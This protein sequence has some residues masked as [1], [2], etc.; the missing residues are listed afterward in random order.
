[1]NIIGKWKL[2]G[3]RIPTED[4]FK[5]YTKDNIPQE[6]AG[7]LDEA[8]DFDLEFLENGTYN[9]ITK[10]VGQYAEEAEKEGLEVRED[11]YFVVS[12]ATWEDRNGTVYYDSGA[13]G[14]IL[15]EEVD[16]FIPLEVTDDGCI[17]YNYGML[18]YE[19]ME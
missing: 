19:R 14:T 15:E 1:M 8:A 2:K 13:E 9:L 5:L 11:G 12:S 6:H 10:A 7:V 4:G 3:A 17:F 18:L 16:P